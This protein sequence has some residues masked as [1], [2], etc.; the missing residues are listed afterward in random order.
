[1][2]T[3]VK[4]DGSV[5]QGKQEL[6]WITDNAPFHPRY[7]GHIMDGREVFASAVR[8]LVVQ[9]IVVRSAA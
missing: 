8:E 2:R 6:G 5:W 7:V 9:A 4:R 1:M 3:I